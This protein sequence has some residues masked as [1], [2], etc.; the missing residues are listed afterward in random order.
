MVEVR[1]FYVCFVLLFSLLLIT[2]GCNVSEVPEDITG[3]YTVGSFFH[4]LSDGAEATV[5]YPKVSGGSE[6]FPII[7]FSGGWNLARFSYQETCRKIAEHGYIVISRFYPTLGYFALGLTLVDEHVA[8]IGEIIDW[9]ISENNRKG[10]VLFDIVDSEH[11]GLIGHSFGGECTLAAA[12]NDPR[13]D[14]AVS[15]DLSRANRETGFGIVG[16]ITQTRAAIMYIVSGK[17][18]YCSGL[19]EELEALYDYSPAP[20]IEVTIKEA[21][22]MDFI[23]RVIDTGFFGY[24]L[25]PEGTLPPEFVRAVAR[26]YYVPWF[27]VHLKGVQEFERYYNGPVSQADEASGLVSIRR[28]LQ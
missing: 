16:D 20:T 21:G 26:R 5:F 3:S 27:N 6:R 2:G 11:V 17:G 19:L 18:G 13:V 9:C 12:V 14:A 8:Q 28:R 1:Q 7:I 25:C 23:E 24:I 22:H 15:L 4:K 10:S